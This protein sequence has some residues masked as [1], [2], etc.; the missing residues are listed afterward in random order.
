MIEV[1]VPDAP[2]FAYADAPYPMVEYIET[3]GDVV[4]PTPPSE[5]MSEEIVPEIETTAVADA[6][7]AIAADTKK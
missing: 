1:I 5:I 2:T 4:Y 7:K 6:N 3:I